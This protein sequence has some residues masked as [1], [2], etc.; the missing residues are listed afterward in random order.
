MIWKKIT[1]I[2]EDLTKI[3]EEDLPQELAVALRHHKDTLAAERNLLISRRRANESASKIPAEHIQHYMDAVKDMEVAHSEWQRS[4]EQLK[5][6]N[7]SLMDLWKKT[8]TYPRNL[9]QK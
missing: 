5:D 6:Q 3:Q 2:T 7:N 1:E 8:V 9:Q 4:W